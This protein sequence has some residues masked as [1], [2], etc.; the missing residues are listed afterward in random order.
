MGEDILGGKMSSSRTKSKSPKKAKTSSRTSPK[1]NNVMPESNYGIMFL[2][3]IKSPQDLMIKY[4]NRGIVKLNK[5][6]NAD[7]FDN[8]I[9]KLLKK[10]NDNVAVFPSAR[11]KL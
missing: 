7:R 2:K 10:N 11:S 4:K 5:D 8:F 1:I 9:N 3:K 6:I